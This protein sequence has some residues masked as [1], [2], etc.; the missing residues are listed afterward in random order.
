MSEWR[1]G[2]LARSR[3]GHSESQHE[4]EQAKVFSM[5][6]SRR[7]MKERSTAGRCKS[8]RRFA[9]CKNDPEDS[10]QGVRY[11]VEQGFKR[12]DHAAVRIRTPPLWYSTRCG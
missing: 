12:K 5:Q 1:S 11:F 6:Q 10:I 3:T 9:Q 2:I 4:R 8:R 7:F